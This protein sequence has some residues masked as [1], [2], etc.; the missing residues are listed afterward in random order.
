MFGT[1][2]FCKIPYKNAKIPVLITSDRLLDDVFFEPNKELIIYRNFKEYNIKI[3]KN[4]KIYSSYCL[5]YN[6]MIIK[7]NEEN[8]VNFFLSSLYFSIKFVLYL[9]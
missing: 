1:G 9:K 7:L 2:F 8:K 6:I 5:D 4:N 3:D